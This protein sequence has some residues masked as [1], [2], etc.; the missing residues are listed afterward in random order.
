MKA[1]P[2][3]ISVVWAWLVG[4]AA[5]LTRVSLFTAGA[6]LLGGA[7]SPRA[8]EA[9]AGLMLLLVGVV[10]TLPRPKAPGARLPDPEKDREAL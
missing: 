1:P 8:G 10:S 9:A 7:F 4:G 3:P 6:A 5:W 2:L